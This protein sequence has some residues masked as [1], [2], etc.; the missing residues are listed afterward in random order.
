MF[1][2]DKSFK[3]WTHALPHNLTHSVMVYDNSYNGCPFKHI[4]V[5]GEALHIYLFTCIFCNFQAMTVVF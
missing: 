4:P 5:P 3:N 1:E 2:G